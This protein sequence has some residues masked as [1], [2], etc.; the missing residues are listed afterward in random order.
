MEGKHGSTAGQG[1][2]GENTN[3]L[4]G[5]K[6]VARRMQRLQNR[7]RPC[8]V[9]DRNRSCQ[10]QDLAKSPGLC[11]TLEYDK[12]DQPLLDCQKKEPINVTYVVADQEAR[13]TL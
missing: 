2:L 5:I 12:P 1:S 4:T 13:S 3:E 11:P 7:S 8:F 6:G 10:S 9:I